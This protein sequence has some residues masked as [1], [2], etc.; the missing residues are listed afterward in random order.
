MIQIDSSSY[1]DSSAVIIGN[2]TIGKYCGI[3]PHAVIRG[4][5]NSIAIGDGS[6]VQDCC[7]IHVNEKHCVCIGKNVSL[8][9]CA[10]VHGATIEDNCLIGIHSTVLDG[11]V[12]G[13]GSI[14]GANALVTAGMKI[15]CNS[16]VLGVPGKVVKQD[17]NFIDMIQSNAEVYKVLSKKHLEGKFA[18]YT[19]K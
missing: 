11:A 18:V 17:R 9:H 3:Y 16:L 6:N 5:Q 14:I 4:D 8:G 13:S 19:K 2:V 12:I 15:P 1:I 7:V 10:M